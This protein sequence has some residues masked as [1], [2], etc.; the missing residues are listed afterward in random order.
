MTGGCAG[1]VRVPDGPAANG[2]LRRSASADCR[3][4]RDPASRPGPGACVA[5]LV[6]VRVT[7]RPAKKAAL[8]VRMRGIPEIADGDWVLL[9]HGITVLTGRN[10]VGKT[11]LLQAIA[12]LRPDAPCSSPLPQARI[13]ADDTVI[14]LET[15]P[16]AVLDRY[17]VTSPAGTTTA[18][19][20]Q[21][22]NNPGTTPCTSAAG[23]S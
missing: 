2:G 21:D 10:N 20:H 9:T 7:S 6:C 17:E 18:T 16:Q 11:R 3:H 19:W 8:S 22:P 14:E 1:P 12:A 5:R 15:G 23:P 4:G 13:E